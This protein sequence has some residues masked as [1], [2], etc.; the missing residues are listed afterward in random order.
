[1]KYLFCVILLFFFGCDSNENYSISEN[2]VYVTL[3]AQSHVAI[4]ETNQLQILDEISVEELSDN[5][6]M[7][8]PHDI[9]ID[10][11][12]NFWFTT[13]MM[14]N[15]VGMYSIID[16]RLISTLSINQMP[17]LL[18]INIDEQKLYVSRGVSGNGITT[19]VIYELS[20]IN[21]FLEETQQWDVQFDYAH[22][23]HFDKD[24]GFLFVVG[25]ES[26]FIAKINPNEPQIPFQN[27]LL[28]S[29]DEEISNNFSIDVNRLRPIHIS[30][31]YPFLF[32]T[33]S[34]GEWNSEEQ[35]D[36]IQGQL[37]M[38]DIDSM[39]LLATAEFDTYSRPWHLQASD[40]DNKVFVSLSGGEG[41]NGN[42]ES[43]VAC[44]EYS[45]S[46]NECQLHKLWENKSSSYGTMHGLTLES[47]CD[48]NYFV[49]SSGRN[50]GTVY[51]FDPLTGLELDRKN[52]MSTGNIRTGGI[53]IYQACNSC[54]D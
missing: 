13:A 40:I 24:S 9:A 35:Y 53:D 11:A 22:G 5:G 7:S 37:Q 15:K 4:V 27:P 29:M 54:C 51:K 16:N 25:K 47:D 39:N 6:V 8:A 20:Y 10:N 43:G 48:G 3:Q 32:I 38:W 34:A 45:C 52:L 17:A 33:C 23:I 44:V 18:A 46:N 19:N 21:G 14:G 42:D 2:R 31:K 41:A 1:M 12:N 50:D 49:Y 28:I 26:D 30:S 36:E